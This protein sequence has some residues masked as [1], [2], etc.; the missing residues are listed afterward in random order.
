MVFSDVILVLFYW[1]AGVNANFELYLASYL[2]IPI[3][4]IQLIF[5]QNKNNNLEY[6]GMQRANSK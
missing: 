6:F 1:F 3:L 4:S 5:I 2:P